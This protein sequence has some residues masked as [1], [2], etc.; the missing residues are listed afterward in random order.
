MATLHTLMETR[1]TGFQQIGPF[2]EMEVALDARL[3]VRTVISSGAGGRRAV[4]ARVRI[5]RE[6]MWGVR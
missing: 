5:G 6:G 4:I 2:A 3:D 1:G